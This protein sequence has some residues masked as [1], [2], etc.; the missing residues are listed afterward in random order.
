M[1]IKRIIK[2]IESLQ[3]AFKKKIDSVPKELSESMKQLWIE[4]KTRWHR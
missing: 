1:E 2:E 4:D 3:I